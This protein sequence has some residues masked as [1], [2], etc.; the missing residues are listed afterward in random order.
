MK[1]N[2]LPSLIAFSLA[3]MATVGSM[4]VT[5]NAAAQQEADSLPGAPT[6]EITAVSPQPVPVA[7]VDPAS[8]LHDRVNQ[9]AL[10][11]D[12]GFTGRLSLLSRPDGSPAP[13]IAMNV[14]I[15]QE[16]VDVASAI[17]NPEGVFSVS[18]LSEGVAVVY[19]YS[20]QGMVLFS[21][22]LVRQGALFADATP[23]SVPAT[24]AA[25]SLT[26]AVVSGADLPAVRQMVFGN[27]QPQDRRFSQPV[28][29]A[30]SAYQFGEGEASTSVNSQEVQ[31]RP[32]GALVGEVNLLDPRTGRY[33]EVRDLMLH[34]F[35][36]GQHVAATEVKADGSFR[37]A[38][39]APGVHSIVTTGSDGTLALGISIV[40][41]LAQQQRDSQ[42]KLTS[43]AQSLDLAVS[44]AN[45]LNFNS[46]NAGQP[47]G[48]SAQPGGEIV[49]DAPFGPGMAGG[50][51]GGPGG[52]SGSGSGG[53]GG[54][55]GGGGGLGALLG[56]A[57]AGALG[58]ALGR[59][60]R[61]AS[62]NR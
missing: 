21:V 29:E 7:D 18:G 2:S 4:Y 14:R 31:L 9:V 56:A 53:G 1:T 43:V 15:I 5:A 59:D 51:F 24:E 3:V 22:R 40:G 20:D 50:P 54:G 27:L 36:D 23:V 16:G 39:L 17:T 26:S 44:P 30:D 57:A 45:V 42:Y 12:G 37:I 35:R 62:P 6:P 55:I 38:G 61:T 8:V 19:G 60:R 46:G 33:R 47:S 13:A 48:P 34:F 11:A 52:T 32:D 25:V 58:Y 28:T 41:S 10:S 49:M